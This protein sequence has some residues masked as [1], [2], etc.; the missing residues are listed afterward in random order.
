MVEVLEDGRWL[1]FRVTSVGR[2]PKNAFPTARV[3][4]PTPDAQLRLITCGGEF[5]RAHSS[6]LDNTVVYA[7]GG[8]TLGAVGHVICARPWSPA[9]TGCT[10]SSA[11]AGWAWCGWP[12]TRCSVA[13]WPSSRSC[14]RPDCP[15][16]SATSCAFRT[17]REAR[18]TARLNHPNVVK[19]Y[20]VVHTEE[21]PWI[22]MEFV[23]SRSLYDVIT[24]DG[25]LRPDQGRPGRAGRCS[26]R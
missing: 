8:V 18:T 13:T 19:I 11:R 26:P 15:R 6:Y 7:V 16:R 20:D 17:L 10:S 5:D 3:Y 25:P 9:G 4:G 14:R 24:T 21:W 12:A 1:P 22:V 2:Y 23:P